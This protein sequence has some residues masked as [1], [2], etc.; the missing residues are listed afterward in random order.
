MRSTPTRRASSTRTA[1][2]TRSRARTFR[3]AASYYAGQRG[4]E[5]KY[6]GI[7]RTANMSIILLT[8]NDAGDV[9]VLLDDL[10]DTTAAYN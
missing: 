4:Q 2:A 6:R 1:I 7:F 10:Y 8:F 5:V 9:I 3:T